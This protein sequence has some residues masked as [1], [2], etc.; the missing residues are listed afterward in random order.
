MIHYSQEMAE[1]EGDT[2]FA[3]A[4]DQRHVWV[5]KIPGV[6][7]RAQEGFQTYGKSELKT[8]RISE[9]QTWY[10]ETCRAK[11]RGQPFNIIVIHDGKAEAGYAGGEYVWALRN[12]LNG[13][14]YNGFTATIDAGELED[15]QVDRTDFLAQWKESYPEDHSTNRAQDQR[16]FCRR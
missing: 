4:E 7:Y 15:L 9:L 14:Q 11:W 1:Y 12:G 13:D 3:G 6:V 16:R 8:V 2:Y 5:R 10:R